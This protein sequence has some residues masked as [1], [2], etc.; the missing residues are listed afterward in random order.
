MAQGTLILYL[1]LALAP[2]QTDV[3][4]INQRTIRIPIR[5]DPARRHEIKE[6]ILFSSS[7]QGKTWQQVAVAPPEQDGFPFYAPTDGI[8]WFSVCVVDQKGNREP[9]D[10]YKVPP[11]QKILV[12][13]LKPL[14]RIVST[15]RQGDDVV[16]NWEMQEDHPDLA[17]LKLEYRAVDGSGSWYPATVNPAATGQTRFR[18]IIPGALSLRMQVQDVA[19]NAC[20]ANAEVAA[21]NP[22]S[23]ASGAAP[24][25]PVN[26]APYSTSSGLSPAP[27]LAAT[28]V[29]AATG[30]PNWDVP[31]SAAPAAASAAQ[32][33]GPAPTPTYGQAGNLVA[34]SD[35]YTA[36]TRSASGQIPPVTL[37]RSRSITLNYEVSKVGP[38]GIG[39]VEL[40]LTRDDGRTWERFAEDADLTPPMNVELPG[41]GVFGLSLLLQSKAGMARRPPAPGD[42]PEMRIEV[43]TTPPVAQLF[44]PEPDPAQRDALVLSW[45]ATDRNLAPNP[46]TLQWAAQRDGSWQTIKADLPNTGR[47]SWKLPESIPYRVYLRLIAADTAGNVGIAETTESQCIDLKEPE[48]RLLG[49]ATVTPRQP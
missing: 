31:R 9:P 14:L 7:D 38:S 39:K 10:I 42:I 15:D 22:T 36:G 2:G 27:A 6:L 20:T 17:T 47:Y 8:Y 18:P 34:S 35:S 46:I 28:N 24:G 4:P 49:I 16:V 30:T 23:L 29:P 19:Q 48:G 41:E 1:L 21:G 5:V 37:V 33:T 32:R 11:S 3:W 25:T 26:P 13:T 45:N 44:H 40:W 43:D 12:D